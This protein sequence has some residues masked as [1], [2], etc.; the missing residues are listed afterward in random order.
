MDE[1]SEPY[2]H[3]QTWNRARELFLDIAD[4]PREARGPALAELEAQD[5]HLAGYVRRLLAKDLGPEPEAESAP[6]PRFGAYQATSLIA[7]G[8][9]GEVYLAQR[10]DGE[11]ERQVAI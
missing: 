3:E 9:M 7:E 1:M 8:G 10:S 2:D 6:L 5:E 11:F 4:L